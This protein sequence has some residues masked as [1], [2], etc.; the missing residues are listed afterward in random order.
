MQ[1]IS[2]LVLITLIL[3]PTMTSFTSE[4]KFNSDSLVPSSTR[5]SQAVSI[6]S[7]LTTTNTSKSLSLSIIE[8]FQRLLKA[9]EEYDYE[10]VMNLLSCVF[11]HSKGAGF[12]LYLAYKRLAAGD[13][14]G[15]MELLHQAWKK[16]KDIPF[17]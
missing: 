13:L 15:L 1:I 17:C 7:I 8:F 2:I 14:T 12:M 6:Q 4:L 5:T 11:D 9:I 3:S 10:S 16:L